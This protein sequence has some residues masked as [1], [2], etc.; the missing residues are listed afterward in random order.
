MLGLAGAHQLEG[1]A[2]DFFL[3]LLGAAG[4][5]LAALVG[6]YYEVLSLSLD[7]LDLGDVAVKLADVG[8]DEGVAFA[9]LD[10]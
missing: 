3:C 9:I 8:A 7:A 4:V 1:E 5:A 10:G 6:L 2:T